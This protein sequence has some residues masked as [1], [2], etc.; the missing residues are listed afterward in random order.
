MSPVR[1]VLFGFAVCAALLYVTLFASAG[2][3]Q[4]AML[5]AMAVVLIWFA[6]V[7]PRRLVDQNLVVNWRLFGLAAVG[8]ALVVAA[9]VALASGTMFLV[10]SVGILGLVVGT[11]RAIRFSM[12]AEM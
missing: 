12:Q 11:V 10:L 7:D 4:V 3:L 2:S 5:V 8:L 1:S 6:T 9:M